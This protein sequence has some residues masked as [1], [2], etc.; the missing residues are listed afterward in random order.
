MGLLNFLDKTVDFLLDEKNMRKANDYMRKN[1]EKNKEKQK[2]REREAQEIQNLYKN[3]YKN[4]SDSELVA[5]IR[6]QENGRHERKAAL[7]LLKER[8][9]EKDSDGV[10]RKRR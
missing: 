2:E 7:M 3:E 5:E 8:G 10:M 6:N 4:L 9:W 1:I